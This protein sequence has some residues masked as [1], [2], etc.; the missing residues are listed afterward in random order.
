MLWI[1]LRKKKILQ[2]PFKKLT[3][4]L[5]NK[6]LMSIL[7]GF[8]I[9]ICTN[10]FAQV[11][12]GFN[13]ISEKQSQDLSEKI[14]KK[15][16][17]IK[18][19]QMDFVQEKEMK[20]MRNKAVMNGKLFFQKANTLKVEYID[21]V[22]MHIW[23]NNGQW[24]MKD[25]K[26]K[27]SKF[28]EKSMPSLY[29]INQML[30]ESVQGSIIKSKH[31]SSK[32]YENKQQYFVLL[33]PQVKELQNWFEEIHL[34]INKSDLLVQTILLKENKDEYTLMKMKQIQTNKPI[35]PNVFKVR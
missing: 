29:Y 19:M 14:E 17:T 2:F 10:T 4:K 34:Y 6:K 3:M 30:L 13:I 27:I 5:G 9:L 15:Q 20:M 35:N 7:L 16:A 25:G 1:S 23:M 11:P 33:K 32:V 22:V 31:F 21:P 8:L 12:A 18:T 28:N 26:G 24:A